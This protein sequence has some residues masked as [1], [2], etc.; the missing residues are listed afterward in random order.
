MMATSSA[1]PKRREFR[2]CCDMTPA[3]VYKRTPKLIADKLEN[4]KFNKTPLR[5]PLMKFRCW[6]GVKLLSLNGRP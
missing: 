2:R 4:A 5:F 1:E 3:Q 6:G